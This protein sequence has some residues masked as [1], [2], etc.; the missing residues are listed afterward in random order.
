MYENITFETVLNKL[1]SKAKEIN[2]SIDFR[3]GSV[4]YMTLAPVAMEIVEMYIE[5]NNIMNETF[6]DTASREYLIKR[7]A[8]R[9]IT[10]APA[11]QAVLKAVFTPETLTV[12]EG[13][14]F[15]LENW[16]YRV[17]EKITA[18]QYRVICEEYGE[19]GNKHFG[20]LIPIQYIAGL[21]TAELV[22]VLING[23]DEEDTESLRK[24]YFQSLE[25]ESFGGNKN[26]YKTKVALINGVGGVKVYSGTEWNGGGTVKVVITDSAFEMPTS[27]LIDEVQTMLDPVANQGEG[28]GIAPIGHFVTVVGVNEQTVNVSSRL[29]FMAGYTWDDVKDEA[30]TVIEDYFK[31]M[32]EIWAEQNHLM[33]RISQIETRLLG[34]VGI[35]DISGTKLNGVEENCLIAKDSIVK[36]GEINAE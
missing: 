19:E 14:R 35:A 29:T 4:M 32:N 3:E 12:P 27:T 24:R 9:G 10:P 22:E 6:A 20:Q 36:L 26:D 34:I 33:V 16:N 18:G 31:S 17:V 28:I 23:E 13:A 15:S 1:I 2:S 8:E 25:A 5:C 21:E 7:A 30:R 11:T